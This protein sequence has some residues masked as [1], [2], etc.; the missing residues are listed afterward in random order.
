N[1]FEGGEGIGI[2]NTINISSSVDVSFNWWGHESGPGGV[3]PGHGEG[4]SDNVTFARFYHDDGF[5]VFHD[6][7]CDGTH[8][9]SIQA[10]LDVASAGDTIT[11]GNGTYYGNL[12]IDTANLTIK[13]NDS[14][15][16][17]INGTIDVAISGLTMINN[18]FE[19]LG[20]NSLTTAIEIL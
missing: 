5:E 6:V 1:I 16:T 7:Y 2:N 19:G 3:G 20:N 13:S 18:T 8:Y 12:T 4:V 11:V 14:A 10:A 9:E 17:I 15:E